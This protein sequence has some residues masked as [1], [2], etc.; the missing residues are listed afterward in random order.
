MK[1][2]LTGFILISVV[3]G[4]LKP[5]QYSIIPNIG[6]KG[7]NSNRIKATTI[8]GGQIVQGDSLLVQLSFT[9]GDGDIGNLADDTIPNCFIVDSRFDSVVIPYKMP[10]ISPKG[11]IKVVSGIIQITFPQLYLRDAAQFHHDPNADTLHYLIYIKDR[12]QHT[13]NTVLTQDI[14][15]HR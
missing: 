10:D 5:P 14:Y 9:D 2:L 4:C 7:V 6:F 1:K 8:T 13:S 15:L 3:S 12:A 11:N